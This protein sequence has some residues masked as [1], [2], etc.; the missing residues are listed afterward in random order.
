M[1]T[2]R[3]TLRFPTTPDRPPIGVHQSARG[4]LMRVI[5]TGAARG[6]GRAI[7][8][9]LAR[10]AQAAGGARLTLADVHA[11][12]LHSLAGEL[13]ALGG[14]ARGVPGDLAGADLSARPVG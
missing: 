13:G 6:I 9:R 12:E 14:H 7:A 10:D 3:E 8:L 2:T 5:V 4:R 1:E 11:D